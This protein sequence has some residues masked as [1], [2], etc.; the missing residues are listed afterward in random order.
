MQSQRELCGPF[1]K[2]LIFKNIIFY[3][4]DLAIH[5]SLSFYVGK[6]N[7]QPSAK[8]KKRPLTASII[9]GLWCVFHFNN[10]NKVNET[11]KRW[12]E[13]WGHFSHDSFK[14]L[15]TF[16]TAL[17]EC[18]SGWSWLIHSTAQ[19]KIKPEW[20]QSKEWK[21]LGLKTWRGIFSNPKKINKTFPLSAQ[22][23]W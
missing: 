8:F 6:I 14:P 19:Q 13:S 3:T 15:P 5:G 7:A 12:R 22:I 18:I 16:G 4:G 2:P 10:G 21:S 9:F 17:F 1:S 20:P 11:I 23:R